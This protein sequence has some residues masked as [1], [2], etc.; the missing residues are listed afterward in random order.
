V[1]FPR[2]EGQWPQDRLYSNATSELIDEEVKAIV[3]EAYTR[4]LKLV[5]ERREQVR[6]ALFTTHIIQALYLSLS[7]C[8][9]YLCHRPGAPSPI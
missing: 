3:A 6:R 1:S 5:E 4:T 9:P 8:S 7:T 2:E